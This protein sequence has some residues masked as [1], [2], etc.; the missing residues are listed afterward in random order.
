MIWEAQLKFTKVGDGD[1]EMEAR[2]NVYYSS[3]RHA[4]MMFSH[5]LMGNHVF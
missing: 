1:M 3:S 4:C 2:V 5:I